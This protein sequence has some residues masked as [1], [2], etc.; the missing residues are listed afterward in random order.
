MVCSLRWSLPS[1]GLVD[2]FQRVSLARPHS[3]STKK[4]TQGSHIAPLPADDLAHVGFGDFQFDDIVIEMIDENFIG[5]IHHPLGNFLD[6]HADV[7]G[8]FGHGVGLGHRSRGGS[9]RLGVEFAD[10]LGH[11]RAL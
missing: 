3:R 11:L 6:E 5:R 4:R 9:R 1:S 7:C 2:D 10:A 8:Y